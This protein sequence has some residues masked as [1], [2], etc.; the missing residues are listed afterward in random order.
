[1]DNL[2]GH[3]VA[4][5]YTI[6]REIGRGG[7]ATVWLAH[8]QQHARKVAIKTLHPDLAGAIG[9]DRF[10]REI[11]LTAQL[12]HPGI[13]PILDSGAIEVTGST[14][15]PWY[16][17]PFLDGESL[18]ARLNREVQL[19]IDEAL[20]ITEAVG[21]ALEAAHRV[22]VVHRDI[23]P[24][25]VFLSG[26][27]V[28]V[29]DFG[30]AKAIAATDAERLTST[31]LAIGTPAYM[32]PEQVVGGTVDARSDQYSLASMLYEMIAGEPPFS[33]P[34]AQATLARRL[35][36]PARPLSP[37]RS[38]VPPAV[39]RATLR[40]L[41]R[42]PAD[43]FP[44]VGAF[45]S[46]LRAP[47]E[48]S[49]IGVQPRANRRRAALV[50]G[51]V[52]TLGLASW[53][54]ISLAAG[55]R[56]HVVA[57]EVIAL[58]Q[59][60]VQ[61]YDRRTPAGVAEAVTTLNDVIRRDSLFAAAWNAL[62]KTYVRA[63]QRG[64]QVPDVTRDQL[65]QLALNA[66]NRSIAID[67]MSADAWTTHGMVSQQFDPT[68][69]TPGLQSI[70]RAIALDSTQAPA[71]H[72]YAMMT[73]ESGNL[74]GGLEA[75]RRSVRLSPAYSQGLA[76]MALAHYWQGNYDS[77]AVWADSGIR[78]DPNYLLARQTAA[79]IA[80]ERGLFDKARDHADAAVRLSDDVEK[81]NSQANAVLVAARS[82]PR[83]LAQAYL[84]GVKV[85]AGTYQPTTVHT[86]VYLAEVD[87]AVGDIDGAMRTL[88]MYQTRR[89]LH[90]QLHL[91]CSPTFAPMAGD[92]RFRA[93]LVSPR[94]GPG[95][96]C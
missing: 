26:A 49:K 6:E 47:D 66:V 42:T 73:A 50:G 54:V 87:A 88:G 36:E 89:D 74:A 75:W 46:A 23:K 90:F 86:A 18:R 38:T 15:L 57:P 39:E 60:G 10:L 30:I 63:W 64:F 17:M 62:A 32:S 70:R 14:P 22:G 52:I 48:S 51:A 55:A 68:D 95:K 79:L 11:R 8:D 37:V 72:F 44:S 84:L 31:G 71:W 93:L 65:L 41:E 81:V 5:R 29:V 16:A 85:Q 25:N 4:S 45:L 91:R 21:N 77:A 7:M 61:A 96:T 40:A 43:R 35:A 34:N 1:M 82:G 20:R 2:S 67:S 69:V 58:Y 78:V 3:V 19:P 56:P 83:G 80:I 59:R 13:V 92:S 28:Y 33:G 27:L 9:T 94:P 12:Q 53:A 24:E 76:F